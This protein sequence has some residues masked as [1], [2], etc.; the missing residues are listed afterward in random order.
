MITKFK[1]F[2]NVNEGE[3][4]SGCYIILIDDIYRSYKHDTDKIGYA[5]RA[6]K[7]YNEIDADFEKPIGRIEL[8]FSEVKYWSKNKEDLENLLEI[9]IGKYKV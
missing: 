8:A 5:W 3:I 6:R 2:E 4:E 9:L 7:H 1:I